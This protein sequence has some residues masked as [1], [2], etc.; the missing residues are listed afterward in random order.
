M[1]SV[2]LAD[3]QELVREG[4]ALI[5]DAQPDMEVVAQCGDGEAAVDVAL[6]VGPD[7][8]LMDVRMPRLDGIEATRRIVQSG[9]AT[10]VVVV[11]TYDLDSYVYEALRNGASGYLLKTSPRAVLVQAIRTVMQGDV[12]VAPLET[13]KLIEHARLARLEQPSPHAGL[14][15]LSRRELEVLRAVA[16]GASNAEVA[17][18]L[19]ISEKTVKTH[20]SHLLDKLEARDRVQLAVFAYEHDVVRP[21]TRHPIADPESSS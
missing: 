5:L 7:V 6:S 10:R 16:T 11:T 15:R 17:Q 12:L 8:M 4:L 18:R 3:D 19:H 1:I 13:R 14:A 9:S 20:V 2:A 21:G